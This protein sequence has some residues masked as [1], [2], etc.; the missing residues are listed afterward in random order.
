MQLDLIPEHV[1]VVAVEGAEV[2]VP[3][4]GYEAYLVSNMGRFRST[5]KNQVKVNKGNKNHNG[6]IHIGLTRN[7]KQTFYLAH[8]IVA[9]AFC[10]KPTT[11]KYLIVNHK[12]RNKENNRASNLEWCTVSANTKHW[13]KAA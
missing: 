6:Y 10:P 13:R 8:R 5:Y 4:I 9:E 11:A 3:V 1:D 7:G 2:W 12:D